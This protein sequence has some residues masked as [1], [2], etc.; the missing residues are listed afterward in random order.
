MEARIR[1]SLRAEGT[2]LIEY[3]F[4][5]PFLFLLIVNCVNFGYFLYSWITVSNAARTGVQYA[6]LSGASVGG[7]TPASGSQITTLITNDMASL[8]NTPTINICKCTAATPAVSCPSGGLTTLA[9]TCSGI[10]TDPEAPYYVLTTV[11]VTYAYT[12]PLGALSFPALKIYATIPPTTIIGQAQ[13]RSI[14]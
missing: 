14:Q 13:M 7:L 5:I 4:M 2:A 12:P 1:R 9:G 11:Q 6:V 3:A 10:P 8:P